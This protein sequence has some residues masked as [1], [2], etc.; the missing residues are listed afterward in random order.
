MSAW[1]VTTRFSTMV[2]VSESAPAAPIAL[3]CLALERAT[4]AD[5]SFQ[6]HLDGATSPLFL[7]V[8]RSADTNVSALDN[9]HLTMACWGTAARVSGTGP[10][11]WSHVKEAAA[12][13]FSTLKH[14]NLPI[15]PRLV[16]GFAFDLASSCVHNSDLTAAWAPFDDACFILPKLVYAQRAGQAWFTAFGVDRAAAALSVQKAR[17]ALEKALSSSDSPFASRASTHPPTFHDGGEP[18]WKALVEKAVNAIL[19]RNF[20]KVV[21]S[22]TRRVSFNKRPNLTRAFALLEDRHPTTTRFLFRQGESTFLGASPERLATV[23]GSKVYT[24]ALAGSIPRS[25]TEPLEQLTT[26]LL[27]SAKDRAEH[28]FVVDAV[29]QAL[30]PYCDSLTYPSVPVARVLPHVLHLQT[31]I[32]GTLACHTPILDLV[33]RLHPTPALCGT[34]RA[35]SR[36]FLLENEDSFRGYYGGAVGHLSAD[37]NGTFVVAIRSALTTESSAWIYSGAGIVEH[38]NPSLEY[39]ETSAK[40]RTMREALEVCS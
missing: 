10:N 25:S 27:E 28:A 39:Q 3:V 4:L 5:P 1:A 9:D 24:E 17:G 6:V 8:P 19:H 37:G 14:D 30:R 40:E 34:P 36:A 18:E 29:A 21:L 2:A 33:E 15:A 38:S 12:R 7:W 20:Q 22:R 32:Q 35:E 23:S 11:R 31:P 26:Q 13:L 16:G